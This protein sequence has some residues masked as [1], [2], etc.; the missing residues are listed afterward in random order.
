MY[1]KQN[2][3]VIHYLNE[4]LINIEQSPVIREEFREGT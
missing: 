4:P 3:S 2:L 1:L